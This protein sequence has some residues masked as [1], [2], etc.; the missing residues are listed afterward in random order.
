MNEKVVK[1]K[2]LLTEIYDLERAEAVLS[3]DQLVMMPSGGAEAR[4]RQMALLKKL[5]HEKQT[6]PELGRLLEDLQPVADNL[7]SDSDDACLIKVAMRDYQKAIKVP[8]SFMG[9]FAAHTAATYEAWVKAREAKNF[10]VVA[11]L[12]G[13][14]LEFSQQLAQFQD[15]YQH[16]ADP[17]IDQLD[18]G[19][20]VA[21]IRP[22]FAELRN[23]LKPLLIRIIAAQQVDDSCLKQNFSE[24]GQLQFGKEVITK[25]GFDF[26]R[27]RDD[28]SVHPFTTSFS[29]GDVRITTRIQLNNL[30]D[31]L[32]STLHEA[33]HALYEQSFASDLEGTLLANGASMGMHESQSRLWENLVG[34][35]RGFWEHFYPRLQEI[36]PEQLAKVSLETFYRAINKVEPS[37]IRTEADEVTYNLHV[38]IRFE[39]ELQLLEGTLAVK[40]LPE[41]WN[42]AYH[43]Y[44]GVV[45]EDHQQGVLQDI[46]WYGGTIGGNFQCYTLGNIL[47]AQIFEAALATH[48]KI[49]TEITQG[50]FGTLR[51]WL[52]KEIYR[53]GRKFSAS[54]LVQRITGKSLTIEPYFKYLED[55]YQEIY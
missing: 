26:N 37:L 17:L 8:A 5:A 45:P 18:E 20:T 53:H 21:M 25:Y 22:L 2:S 34:R 1:L 14:S 30:N 16:L 55:K 27:G 11:S 39:L 49:K 33:G 43:N 41:A 4:G 46:H 15:G 9:E 6:A 51:N 28:L 38:M 29:I 7:N 54:E 35:S 48:P 44:L 32:F 3:W 42:E 52:T 47:S 12:F 31:A 24:A 10:G 36:F 13:K 40:D 50:E 19:F 23:R